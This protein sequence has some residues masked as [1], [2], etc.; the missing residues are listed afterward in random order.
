MSFKASKE[1]VTEVPCLILQ[2]FAG[3][4]GALFIAFG[5]LG[6]L[7]LGLYVDRTKHFT[8]AIKI[9]LSLTSVVFVAFALVRPLLGPLAGKEG[10]Q[11]WVLCSAR[12]T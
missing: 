6:A 5:I 7:V 3:L 4:C 12:V 8:G 11:R 1:R 9:G 2:D 10:G